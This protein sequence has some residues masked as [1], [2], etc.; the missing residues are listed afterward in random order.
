[1]NAKLK[2]YMADAIDNMIS[3]GFQVKLIQNSSKYAGFLDEDG[4]VFSCQISENPIDWFSD[5]VHEYCHFCQ[6]KEKKYSGPKW[7]KS[8]EM[9]YSWVAGDISLSEKD[10]IY[11]INRCKRIELDCEK[12]AVKEIKKYKLNIERQEFL[13]RVGVL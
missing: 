13:K 2:K 8:I 7:M 11:H 6:W 9:V 1:M 12:R 4:K 10:R 5:F 3:A